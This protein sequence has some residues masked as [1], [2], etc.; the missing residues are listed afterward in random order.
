MT[1]IADPKLVVKDLLAS[2]WDTTNTPED[3]PPEFRTGWR[4]ADLTA[5]QITASHD[6]ESPTSPTG[7]TGIGPD[8][9]T[10]QRRGT[11][12]VN[13]WTRRD[14]VSANP[15]TA[16][17]EFSEEIKRIIGEFGPTIHAYEGFSINSLD[18]SDYRYLSWLERQF[19][20]EESDDEDVPIEYRYRVVLGYEYLDG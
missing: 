11:L 17:Y 3:S 10:S 20:P 9:P 18:A 15:K 14:L 16:G 8:G 1:S 12:R 6:E 19:M 5:T 13:V 4:D 2:E 7:F